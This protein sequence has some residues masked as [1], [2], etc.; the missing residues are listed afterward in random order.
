[1]H[2]VLPDGSQLE[3]G[4]PC[5]AEEEVGE[6]NDCAAT[7][8]V[9]AAPESRLSAAEDH[10]QAQTEISADIPS[11]NGQYSAAEYIHEITRCSDTSG[12]EGGDL[13]SGGSYVQLNAAG[14]RLPVVPSL[15]L[16]DVGPGATSNYEAS[17]DGEIQDAGEQLKRLSHFVDWQCLLDTGASHSIAPESLSAILG[18]SP[19]TARKAIVG[20]GE[21]IV[22][23]VLSLTAFL[24]AEQGRVLRSKVDVS[25]RPDHCGAGSRIGVDVLHKLKAVI[26]P[27]PSYGPQPIDTIDVFCV[28]KIPPATD[29]SVGEEVADGAERADSDGKDA[30]T[31][32][33]TKVERERA[34]F[35]RPFIPVKFLK[36]ARRSGGGKTT[37]VDVETMNVLIDT[38]A[39]RSA[40]SQKVRK[41]LELPTVGRLDVRVANGNVDERETVQVRMLV[42]KRRFDMEVSVRNRPCLLGMDFVTQANVRIF[43]S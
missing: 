32:K 40:V 5:T 14:G 21:S 19:H 43:F 41:A 31:K 6:E 11:Q 27:R 23:N 22:L 36:H 35:Q 33:S 17:H 10:L 26:A 13:R 3:R 29:R 39:A 15:K 1:M 2:C 16:S 30:A 37:C 7:G 28:R 8:E 42:A 9:F 38:G 18:V 25:I 34:T 24:K 4:E 12:N 20:S